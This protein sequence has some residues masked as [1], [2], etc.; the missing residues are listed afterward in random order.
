MRGCEVN[1]TCAN[2]TIGTV[3]VPITCSFCDKDYCNSA[4]VMQITIGTIMLCGMIF[5]L[6]NL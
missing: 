6:K 5:I 3:E 4:N 2:I 1:T